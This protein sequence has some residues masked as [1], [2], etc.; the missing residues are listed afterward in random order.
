MA[1]KR[2]IIYMLCESIYMHNYCRLM[3]DY[4]CTSRDMYRY[5][6]TIL[7]Y[8]IC[9]LFNRLYMYVDWYLKV[10]VFTSCI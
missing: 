5:M 7:R 2:Y 3:S 8:V 6:Y 10:Y 1:N 9:C 4:N